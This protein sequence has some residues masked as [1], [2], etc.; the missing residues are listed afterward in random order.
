[1]RTCHH[2]YQY[3]ALIHSH[4]DTSDIHTE[5]GLHALPRP[6][7]LKISE[8]IIIIAGDLVAASDSVKKAARLFPA[9]LA[10]DLIGESHEHCETDLTIDDGLDLMRRIDLGA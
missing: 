4:S 6:D 1:M 2:E 9:M 8:D 3:A 5:H 10:L 7:D